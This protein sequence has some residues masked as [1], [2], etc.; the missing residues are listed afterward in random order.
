MEQNVV[1]L[2]PGKEPLEVDPE[3]WNVYMSV[4]NFVVDTGDI[5]SIFGEAYPESVIR[6]AIETRKRIAIAGLPDPS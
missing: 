2:L 4:L 3:V 1:I 5:T 6:E